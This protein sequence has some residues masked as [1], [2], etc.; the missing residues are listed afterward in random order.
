MAIHR[1]HPTISQQT[2]QYLNTHIV[3]EEMMASTSAKGA[4]AGGTL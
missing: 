2:M 4:Y 3:A 1:R